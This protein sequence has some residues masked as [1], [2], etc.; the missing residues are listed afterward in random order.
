MRLRQV[1]RILD[2]LELFAGSK[3]PLTLTAIARGLS[4]PKSSAFNL[5]ETLLARAIL[6]ETSPRAG[7][8]PTRR[9]F[10]LLREVMEGDPILRGLHGELEVLAESSGETVLLAA[11]DP[12][13]VNMVV[14]LDVVESAAPIR[15]FACIGDKRPIFTTSSGKAILMTYPAEQRRGILAALDYVRHREGT[16]GSAAE[17]E[18]VLA[19]SEARGWCEDLAEYTPEV[20]GLAVPLRLGERRLG[21]AIAGPLYRMT[22]RQRELA[23]LLCAAA[24]KITAQ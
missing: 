21:L 12:Q 22:G 14:Y 18:A 3:T 16:V 2:L 19:R 9:L 13:N 1:D 8:Y 24:R 23:G 20:M 15:Y 10:D 11:R 5:I 17:M 6:Y 4:M 7:Y